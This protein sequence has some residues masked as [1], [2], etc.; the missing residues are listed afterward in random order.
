MER[1]GVERRGL[2][3]LGLCGPGVERWRL[4]RRGVKRP[5]LDRPGLERLGVERVGLERLGVER[6]RVEQLSMALTPARSGGHAMKL[7][8]ATRAVVAV[9][10][11]G[12]VAALL[13]AA[14][15]QPAPGHIHEGQRIVA[16]A[17][18]VLALGSWVW[19][20]VVYRGGESE[21]LNMDEGFFVILA[22]L[23]PPLVTLATLGLATVLAQAARR[24]P[25]VKSAF[26][27][28][29]GLIAAGPGLALG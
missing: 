22:L 8:R 29:Q 24:R 28:G 17:M 1:L 13:V 15:G 16:A 25:L 7:P 5:E 23:E 9:S 3:R 2:E 14:G 19:P 21:A 11:A 12:G 6:H 4:G 20:V 18:G 26:N 10:V 27:V